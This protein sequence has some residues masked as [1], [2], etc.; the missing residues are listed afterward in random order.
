MKS[1][2]S[3]LDLGFM[4]PLDTDIGICG[5]LKFNGFQGVVE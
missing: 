1:K 4:I 2:A 3:F 5:K